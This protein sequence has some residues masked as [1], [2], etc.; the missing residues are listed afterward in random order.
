MRTLFP[1]ESSLLMNILLCD[2]QAYLII[3]SDHMV[4]VSWMYSNVINPLLRA[5][6]LLLF[7]FGY[8]K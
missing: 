7:F 4:S 1:L 3:F 5:F 8:Y 2:I 6:S